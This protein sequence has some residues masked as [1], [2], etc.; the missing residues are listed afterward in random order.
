MKK[1]SPPQPFDRRAFGPRALA[2]LIP[3][4]TRPTYARQ[5]PATAQVIADWA[6]IVGPALAAQT[7]PRRLAAGTLTVACPGPA[8]IELQHSS[9]RLIERINQHVGHALVQR[10]RIVQDAI[11]AP[12]PLP[13]PSPIRPEQRAAVE[14]SL[15]DMPA[16]P[17]REALT[18]L[19]LVVRRR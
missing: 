15:A 3:P 11:G 8:A 6:L 18:A 10:L 1:A 19:G 12:P 4:I 2:S 9:N 7:S 14:S 5:P 13:V 16:G 17:L